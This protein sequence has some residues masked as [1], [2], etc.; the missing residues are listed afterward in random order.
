MALSL[1]VV[2]I[3]ALL[4]GYVARQTK[5]IGVRMALGAKQTNILNWIVLRGLKLIGL[6]MTI[7]IASAVGV[8]HVIANLLYGVTP[9]DPITLSLTILVLGLAGLVACL[10]P[11]ARAARVNPILALRE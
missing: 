3:Y 8:A 1:S 6:G 11:A 9:L 4:A 7:G 5:D 2:G 10:I